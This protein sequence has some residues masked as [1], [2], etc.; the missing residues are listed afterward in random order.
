MQFFRPLRDSRGPT[1]VASFT[2]PI[3]PSGKGRVTSS[4]PLEINKKLFWGTSAWPLRSFLC[5]LPRLFPVS[6]I[7]LALSREFQ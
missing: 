2:E 4:I 7:H 5:P 6:T 1:T 3:G